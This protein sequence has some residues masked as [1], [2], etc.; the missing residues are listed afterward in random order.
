MND[1]CS[2][3]PLV[4]SFLEKYFLTGFRIEHKKINIAYTIRHIYDKLTCASYNVSN[5]TLTEYRSIRVLQ[6]FLKI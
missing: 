4:Y 6:K 3:G 1:T 5:A 2:L